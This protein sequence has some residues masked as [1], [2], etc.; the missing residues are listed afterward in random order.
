MY[1]TK[2]CDKFAVPINASLPGQNRFF[3][4]MLQQWLTMASPAQRDRWGKAENR[5]GG[6]GGG[7]AKF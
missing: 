6:G 4:K 3:E 7:G 5:G 2:A 1:F